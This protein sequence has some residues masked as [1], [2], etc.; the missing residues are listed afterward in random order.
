M[1]KFE[2]AEIRQPKPLP[3][4]TPRPAVAPRTGALVVI[5]MRQETE[6]ETT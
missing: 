3:A 4:V 2:G 6:E 5:V 1:R